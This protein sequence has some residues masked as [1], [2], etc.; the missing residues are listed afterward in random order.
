MNRKKRLRRKRT[1]ARL[2]AGLVALAM[3]VMTLSVFAATEAAAAGESKTIIFVLDGSSM[4]YRYSHELVSPEEWEIQKRGVA[5]L[6][7]DR[8]LF[9]RDGSVMVGVVQAAGG[10]LTTGYRIE[11]Y[12]LTIEDEGDA[13]SIKQA[14][15]EAVQVG[16]LN[17]TGRG[18]YAAMNLIRSFAPDPAGATVCSID[19][20]QDTFGYYDAGYYGDLYGVERVAVLAVEDRE[21]PYNSF[22]HEWLGEDALSRS[23]LGYWVSNPPHWE[24]GGVLGL[25]EDFTQ[26]QSQLHDLCFTATTVRGG[27]LQ[28]GDP[29][30]VTP[31][32]ADVDY[33]DPAVGG[34]NVDAIE[35]VQ[36]IQD[37]RNSVTLVEN[38]PTVARVHV[39]S[40]TGESFNSSGR[41]HA[42]RDGVELPGSPVS[43]SSPWGLIAVPTSLDDYVRLD[44]DNAFVFEL[45]PNWLS[46][47][48][49]LVFNSASG[50]KCGAL[51]TA[52]PGP[53]RGCFV[54]VSFEPSAEVD[55]HMVGMSWEDQDGNVIR[56]PAGWRNEIL[57]R[58]MTMT[59]AS[60]FDVD[61]ASR[62][63]S[64][65]YTVVSVSPLQQEWRI[66]KADDF[67]SHLGG[68]NNCFWKKLSPW[69]CGGN[70]FWL[71]IY[72]A[73]N[74]GA[75]GVAWAVDHT[76]VANTRHGNWEEPYD[77]ESLTV[78]TG[79][80][81]SGGLRNT[82]V[83]EFYHELSQPHTVTDA[84]L[85]YTV[86]PSSGFDWGR[87][88][89]MCGESDEFWERDFQY[90]EEVSP[91][92]TLTALGPQHPLIQNGSSDPLVHADEIWGFDTR[93]VWARKALALTSSH[94]TASLMSYC[95]YENASEQ[96]RWPDLQ[97]Y[98]DVYDQLVGSSSTPEP[99]PGPWDPSAPNLAMDGSFVEGEGT[100]LSPG[101]LTSQDNPANESG[102]I[103]MWTATDGLGAISATGEAAFE[104]YDFDMP[105]GE[106]APFGGGFRFAVPR[107]TEGLSRVDVAFE[108]DVVATIEANPTAPTCSISAISEHPGEP[109]GIWDISIDANDP[110]GDPITARTTIVWDDGESIVAIT[111]GPAGSISFNRDGLPGNT[112]MTARVEVSDGLNTGYCESQPFMLDNSPPAIH[113]TNVEEPAIVGGSQQIVIHAPAWDTED[114]ILTDDDVTWTSDL[115]GTLGTGTSLRA[116][117][118]T[119]SEG[120]H[121]LTATATDSDG[122]TVAVSFVLSVELTAAYPQ[123][124]VPLTLRLRLINLIEASTLDPSSEAW[125]NLTALN[126]SDLWEND[127]LLAGDGRYYLAIMQTI[128]D[129]YTPG[130]P[131]T[132]ASVS[133][134]EVEEL[135]SIA[136]A[137]VRNG[138]GF[139]G[140]DPLPPKVSIYLERADGS[141]ENGHFHKAM[142]TYRKALK[143]GL[144]S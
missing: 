68:Y 82:P 119:L 115:D 128:A 15:L 23:W 80:L 120:T 51:V 19:H 144:R 36:V 142:G 107:P 1:V 92:R 127:N 84:V 136:G 93:F 45:E 118:W 7:D 112:T 27:I 53:T 54:D 22:G 89:G 67:R 96:V 103:F 13:Q 141:A 10:N 63:I 109:E 31:G 77:I 47:D 117:A 74:N 123:A 43:P 52:G 125:A 104:S 62:T 91:Y 97:S 34:L 99:S 18:E 140:I 135:V 76:A 57:D 26:V 25:A 131:G 35:V 101:F 133:E 46:G 137:L 79:F 111:R 73:P 126:D 94:D 70:E 95:K 37:W 138:L 143:V 86:Q 39:W 61:W 17:S 50:E 64:P 108:G 110:G 88:W 49:R 6:L 4:S 102:L 60:V 100:T 98:Q 32:V 24:E 59:P 105:E 38:K 11:R 30:T 2:T 5:S 81:Y 122:E 71:G 41:L 21:G 87:K 29:G 113:F 58:V 33:G 44:R 78:T 8:T 3:T 106:T 14:I 66:P 130:S 42:Y 132:G 75:T 85:P 124:D 139:A 121:L 28:P 65:T 40:D 72:G 114:G 69:A 83:H 20:S 48:V 12:P 9:P 16:G 90:F 134:D 116:S 129:D 56:P 55:L